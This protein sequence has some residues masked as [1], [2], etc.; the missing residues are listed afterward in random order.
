MSNVS[1]K[2]AALDYATVRQQRHAI[3]TGNN[4][5]LKPLTA[6]LY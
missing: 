6:S 3:D 1:I 2:K 5:Y 4:N